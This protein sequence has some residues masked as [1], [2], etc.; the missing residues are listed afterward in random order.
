MRG[1]DLKT[2]TTAKM[3]GHNCSPDTPKLTSNRPWICWA[4][5][6]IPNNMDNP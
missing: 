3:K 4:N 5:T 1:R 6:M 2:F